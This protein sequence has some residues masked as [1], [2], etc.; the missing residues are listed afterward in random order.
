MRGAKRWFVGSVRKDFLRRAN[1]RA[2]VVNLL[3]GVA[4]GW[5]E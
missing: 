4:A 1:G 5:N 2:F 3:Q